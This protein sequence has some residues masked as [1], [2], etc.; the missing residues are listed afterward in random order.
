M[1]LN[2]K[3]REIMA[4][5]KKQYGTVKGAQVFYASLNAGKIS[6]VEHAKRARGKRSRTVVRNRKL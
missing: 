2:E 4:A 3:G 5:M 1:P 6:G